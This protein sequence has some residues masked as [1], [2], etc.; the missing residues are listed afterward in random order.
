MIFKRTYEGAF[1]K[2]RLG[3]APVAIDHIILYLLKNV[4]V[5]RCNYTVEDENIVLLQYPLYE[6]IRS[7]LLH[8]ASQI[9]HDFCNLSDID[10]V[11]YFL[12]HPEIFFLSAK[13]FHNI[14]NRRELALFVTSQNFHEF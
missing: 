14:L 1:A 9:N 4:L 10:K 12:S 2:F 6:T 7:E 5:F 11:G 3:I 8:V 13:T